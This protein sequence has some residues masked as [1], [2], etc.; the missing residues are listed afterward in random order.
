MT[1]LGPSAIEVPA[2]G[3]AAHAEKK[4]F[5]SLD[6]LD[7]RYPALHGFRV[8]AIVS[9]VQYHITWIFAGEQGIPI[10]RTFFEA[11]LSVFFGMDLFFVLSGFLIGSIL[12]RSLDVSG[13]Q[14]IRRFYIRRIFRTFPSY[15][16]VLTFLAV[17]FPMT[18]AQTRHLVWEY[19]YGTN[20]LP[21]ERPETNM[22]WGWSLSLEEQFYLVVPVLFFVLHRLKSDKRRI[23]F[24]TALALVPLGIRLYIYF[25]YRPW[26]DFTLY[27]A[28]YFRTPTRFDTLVVGIILA[29]VHNRYGKRLTVWLEAPF[30]RALLALPAMAC[31]WLLLR[32]NMFGEANVQ[33][34][35]MFAWGTI[36][37]IM[38]FNALVLLL[39][40]DGPIRRHLSYPI[41][42]KV[43]TLGYGVYLV[44]I[45]VIDRLVVPLAKR[46]DEKHVPMAALWPGG[47]LL[48]LALSFFIA[49]FMHL[50]IEKPSLW[51]RQKL[52]G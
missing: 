45:P 28:T 43:A 32:P 52:A 31:L 10:D 23:G 2:G 9:V 22:F 37:S 26:N 6:L 8:L 39:H 20:F 34:V 14:N 41:F 27:G 35:H 5:F 19:V 46:L 18:D 13:T 3:A 42:R 40:T 1:A 11:C 30:S 7:D 17:A 21:L 29:I 33:L 16:I 12:L 15:W 48:T 4:S 50:L 25:R 47:L 49:Y 36:T 24:L 44:H 51:I 38:Y